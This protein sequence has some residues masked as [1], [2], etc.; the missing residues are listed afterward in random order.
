MKITIITVCYNS[1]K[2]IEDTLKSVLNQTYT[3]YEYLIIDGKSSDNTLNIVNSYKNKFKGKM[4]IISEKDKGLYDAMNKGIKMA[5]G[6]VIG[7][8]NSD[9]ILHDKDVFKRI[10]ECDFKKYDG[11][12]SGLMYYDKELKVI[13]SVYKARTGNYN[14]G[15][16]PLHPTL[17]LK[18]EV[19]EKY[20]YFDLNYKIAADYDLIIRILKNGVKLYCMDG[21]SVSMREGGAS[22]G[23]IKKIHKSNM[24]V[25]QALRKNKVRFPFLTM[26]LKFIDAVI[27]RLKELF[28]NKKENK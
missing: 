17:Y 27:H 11:L 25:L 13:K 12:Y 26:S 3:N 5:T 4:T 10:S 6:D 1:E 7:C 18:K 23:S 28:L 22:S 16:Y 15:W 2:T 21:F 14:L 8:I 9:D 20:G 19:F 24:E